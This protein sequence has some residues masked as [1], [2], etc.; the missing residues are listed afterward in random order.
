MQFVHHTEQMLVCFDPGAF[1]RLGNVDASF[2]FCFHSYLLPLRLIAAA[3]D[4]STIALVHENLPRSPAFRAVEAPSSQHWTGNEQ[5]PNRDGIDF[6]S[7]CGPRRPKLPIPRH[8]G[9]RPLHAAA[10][11]FMLYVVAF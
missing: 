2:M 11:N 6:N 7:V 4:R 8:I 1:K 9:R 10:Q 5:A 3:P